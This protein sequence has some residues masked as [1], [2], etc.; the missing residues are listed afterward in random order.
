M[1]LITISVPRIG[2][3]WEGQGGV[4]AGMSLDENGQMYHLIRGPLATDP[5]ELTHEDATSWAAA[6]TVDGHSDFTL[7]TR[8]DLSLLKSTSQEAFRTDDWYWSS[9]RHPAD[10]LIAFA[11]DFEDGD[12][13]YFGVSLK[14]LA[15]AVRRIPI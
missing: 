1:E 3:V 5:D 11:Q 6:Q 14:C 10:E 13:G 15:C 8:R 9:E 7:P 12:Q 4:Y 2:T